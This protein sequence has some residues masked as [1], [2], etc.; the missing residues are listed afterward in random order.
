MSGSQAIYTKLNREEME[1][2]LLEILPEDSKDSQIKCLMLK[3]RCSVDAYSALSYTWGDPSITQQIL[4][5]G[6]KI[7]VTTNL[8]LALFQLRQMQPATAE[9]IRLWVDAVCINQTDLEERRDQVSMMG[10]IYSRA[11]LVTVWLGEE[12]EHTKEAFDHFHNWNDF[13]H[14]EGLEDPVSPTIF[15]EKKYPYPNGSVMVGLIDIF[16]KRKWWTRMWMV[17]EISLARVAKILCGSSEVDWGTLTKILKVWISSMSP[18]VVG[19]LRHGAGP[20]HGNNFPWPIIDLLLALDIVEVTSTKAFYEPPS[21]PRLFEWIYATERRNC[22]DPRDKIFGLLGLSPPDLNVE[23]D[24][25]RPTDVIY[26]DAYRNNIQQTNLLELLVFAGV[27][28]KSDEFE[29]QKEQTE[30]RED[31]S[32]IEWWEERK[33]E[34]ANLPSWVRDFSWPRHSGDSDSASNFYDLVQ[35]WPQRLSASGDMLRGKIAIFPRNNPRMAV[36][37]GILCDTVSEVEGP[38]IGEKYYQALWRYRQLARRVEWMGDDAWYGLRG[39][40]RAKR[41]PFTPLERLETM[42]PIAALFRVLILE[43]D[44]DNFGASQRDLEESP[45]AR[46]IQLIVGYCKI[47]LSADDVGDEGFTKFSDALI[48]AIKD[49]SDDLAASVSH[50]DP[51]LSQDI[52]GDEAGRER[53]RS[54]I[55]AHGAIF[56][57]LDGYIGSGP[58][59]MR[60]GDIVC[61][62]Y[63]CPCPMVIRKERD[64]YL[65]VGPCFVYGMMHGEMIIRTR[66]RSEWLVLL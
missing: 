39:L 32:S 40:Y 36:F 13:L 62:L 19:A 2:R 8:Y 23:P 55:C 15:L 3:A 48:A 20:Y 53:L 42:S 14:A 44:D 46:A 60:V 58:A 51:Y 38:R 5:N 7:D 30:K 31:G 63:N 16:A 47:L 4:V 41:F 59:G 56:T 43:C 27:G 37:R 45:A 9:K 34:T 22:L 65:L 61:I 29:L 35:S 6:E 33:R 28:E 25:S 1:I 64:H 54:A 26:T 49:D 50:L 10:E 66:N 18:Q 17:Q 21:R 24:Y 57:T 52:T 11:S 12:G